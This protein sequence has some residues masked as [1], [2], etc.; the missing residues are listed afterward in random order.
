ME[1][2]LYIDDLHVRS[3]FGCWITRGGYAGLLAFPAMREPEYNDWPEEDG[4]EVDLSEP[5]LEDKEIAI[6]FLADTHV[7]A[8]DLVAYLSEP[9]YH[10]FYIPS[11]GRRWNLRL[12]SQSAG[13]VYPLATS[14]ELKLV[15]DVPVHPV[16]ETMPDPGVRPT[17][18]RY[19]LDGVPF[20]AYG[21]ATDDTRASFL[22]SP[23]A[24]RNMDRTVSTEDGR[25]YDADHLV[26]QKRK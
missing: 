3:R 9:G 18:S 14:F 21:V 22:K 26:F 10:S 24:K 1:N 17:E 4:I 6:P 2:A 12:S 23:T 15:E 5:K 19:L 11:L 13:R 8:T 16:P 7:G 25:I 20:S